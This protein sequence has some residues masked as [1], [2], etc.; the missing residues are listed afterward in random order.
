M[1]MSLYISMSFT[2]IHV[3]YLIFHNEN[4]NNLII[5]N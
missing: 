3:Y 5:N 1:H 4:F 2:Q